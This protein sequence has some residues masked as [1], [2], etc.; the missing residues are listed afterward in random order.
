MTL[1]LDAIDD[2]GPSSTATALGEPDEGPEL[3]RFL[4]A[5]GTGARELIRSTL[6]SLDVGA[7]LRGGGLTEADLAALRERRVG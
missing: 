6:A 7:T 3:E 5:R 4:A 1:P 2:S